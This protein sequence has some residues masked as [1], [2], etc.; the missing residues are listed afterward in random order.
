MSRRQPSRP[1][2]RPNRRGAVAF[3]HASSQ[4]DAAVLLEALDASRRPLRV[5]ELVSVL[6]S[7]S[8]AKKKILN[9]LADLLDA[10][11]LV[12]LPGG[13]YSRPEDLAQVSGELQ[14]QRAGMGFVASRDPQLKGQDVYISSEHLGL[15][16]H[17]DTV[18]VGLL[19]DRRGKSPE[20]VI[21]E[22]LAR[23]QK[24]LLVQVVRSSQPGEVLAS[25][26]DKRQAQHM[27]GAVLADVSGLKSTPLRGDILNTLPAEQLEHGLWRAKAVENL[28]SGEDVP[29]QEAITKLSHGIPQVFPDAVLAEAAQLPP[30]PD[31]SDCGPESGRADLRGLAFV[32]IDG[33]RAK[34]FDDAIYV[35][36]HGRNFLLHVAIA[37]VTHYVRP[38]SALDKEAAL[39]GNSYYFAQ[40]VEPMLP[41][42][43]SNHLCSLRPG[44]NRLTLAARMEFT[45][46]GRPFGHPEFCLAVIKSRARLTYDAVFRALEEKNPIDRALLGELLPMLECARE[47][48]LALQRRR[49]ERG[50][51]F[52]DL[53]ET[54]ALIGESGKVEDI[55]VSPH[56]FAHEL[57]EEFMVAAN[58]AV[59]EFLTGVRELFPYRVHPYPD[60]DKL[61]GL[62]RTL[63]RAG[64]VNV[65]LPANSKGGAQAAA[66]L[67]PEIISR[68]EAEGNEFAVSN[69]VLRAL[70]QARYASELDIHFGLASDCYCH[71]TSPIRRYADVLVH[72]ALRRVL[73]QTAALP[74]QLTESARQ[75]IW[76]AGGKRPVRQSMDKTIEGINT[77]EKQAKDAELELAKRL[78]VLYMRDRVGDEFA[79]RVSGVSEFGV[80]VQLE[81]TLVE[82]MI[83]LA[84]LDDNF[85]Y[86]P[87]RQELLGEYTRRRFSLGQSLRVRLV[88]VH[89]ANLEIT[90]E[91]IK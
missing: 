27:L 69:L 32:T 21:L 70:M 53:P 25:P 52:L 16:W 67:L 61:T 77:C 73:V 34:D 19:P 31:E 41:E 38:G 90:F 82:G 47:L 81:R 6:G 56:N 13:R 63:G 78:A 46:Q 26:L 3:N 10:G 72:R 71:F 86:F 28:G 30:E 66:D 55:V 89:L 84:S 50:A 40:S 58:E 36:R 75:D 57:I 60:A 15:A 80:F 87:E 4:I 20:G 42:A 83:R 9:E 68:A 37:D 12:Y 7:G 14:M 24:N 33:V 43:L 1:H 8:K 51:L 54:E 45:G 5:E 17:G 2:S 91:L 62:F 48:A 74:P 39:R 23:K 29:T 79:C 11:K 22:V 85:I 49:R 18:R 76:A 65:G 64:L 35:E 44:V 88:E 59:A